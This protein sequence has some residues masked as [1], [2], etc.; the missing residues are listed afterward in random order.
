MS[1]F[2]GLGFRGFGFRGLGFRGLGFRV[3]QYF[4][5]YTQRGEI[6]TSR[7]PAL[8]AQA[9]IPNGDMSPKPLRMALS[10]AWRPHICVVPKIKGPIFG[11]PKY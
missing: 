1:A 2:K 7:A 6:L 5:V 9:V 4:S 11:T 3:Y 8:E 10:G